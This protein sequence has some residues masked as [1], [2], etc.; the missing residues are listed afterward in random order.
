MLPPLSTAFAPA[1]IALLARGRIP[2]KLCDGTIELTRRLLRLSRAVSPFPGHVI[3]SCARHGRDDHSSRTHPRGVA[4]RQRG[5]LEREG[6]HPTALRRTESDNWDS[7]TAASPTS[8]SSLPSASVSASSSRCFCSSGGRGPP[9]WASG[10]AQGGRTRSATTASRRRR[11]TS[12]SSHRAAWSGCAIEGWTGSAR[13][14]RQAIECLPVH[15]G[16]IEGGRERA[17]ARY[18]LYKP[19][20]ISQLRGIKRDVSFVGLLTPT[21]SVLTK[22]K[23]QS[24]QNQGYW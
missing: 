10:L 14:C 18:R 13:G 4:S 23:A 15:M 6:Q 2:R 8:S 3:H 1:P 12:R 5:S 7:G 20:S 16:R 17:G 11:G 21:T 19:C 9:L 24:I 22:Q